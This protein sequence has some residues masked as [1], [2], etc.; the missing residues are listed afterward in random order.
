MLRGLA[1]CSQGDKSAQEARPGFEDVVNNGGF[2][3]QYGHLPAQPDGKSRVWGVSSYAGLPT[4]EGEFRE[5]VAQ[6]Y[7]YRMPMAPDC[8]EGTNSGL[9]LAVA[10][11]DATATAPGVAPQ[12]A[13]SADGAGRS[14]VEEDAALLG[15]VA[16]TRFG[17]CALNP[18][19][20]EDLV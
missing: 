8:E 13:V 5:K 12:S 2:G 16:A 6:Q 14:P 9:R 1:P 17:E 19:A 11:P 10:C 15:K 7:G 4:F 20:T 18:S 3:G